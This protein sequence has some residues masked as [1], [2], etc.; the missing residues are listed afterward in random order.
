MKKHNPAMVQKSG[1]AKPSS[2][3]AQARFA[4]IANQFQ[5]AYA[6]GDFKSGVR[7]AEEALR[8]FPGHM[9]ILSDYALCLMRTQAYDKAYDVYMRIRR[10]PAKICAS[11][12]PAHGSTASPKCVAG[13]A[14]PMNCAC[15]AWNH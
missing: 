5:A 9:H 6:N 8:M 15:T 2:A 4:S 13:W 1:G 7:F 12:Q 14:R 3:A 11:R 10:S